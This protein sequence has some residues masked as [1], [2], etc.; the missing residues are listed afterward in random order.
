MAE[1]SILRSHLN[2]IPVHLFEKRQRNGII[3]ENEAIMDV[4]Q[5]SRFRMNEISLFTTR[6][7]RKTSEMRKMAEIS[8]LRSH[9][10]QIPVHLFE[11]RQRNGI[12]YENETISAI[13]TVIMVIMD[14]QPK[15]IKHQDVHYNAEFKIIGQ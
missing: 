12:I 8:I 9:L 13:K 5:I 15:A 7:R 6:T 10:N 11:K 1:I 4:N 14:P 3:Y 2:Q